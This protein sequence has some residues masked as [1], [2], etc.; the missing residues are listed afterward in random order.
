[1]TLKETL[2]KNSAWLL[3]GE[4]SDRIL[5]Y[6]LIII[7]ARMLGDVGLG[8]YSFIFA[9][10]QTTFLLAD[11]GVGDY[12]VREISQRPERTQELFSNAVFLKFALTFT[13]LLATIIFALS[14]NKPVY[15]FVAMIILSG[16]LILQNF[17]SLFEVVFQSRNEMHFISGGQIIERL[18]SLALGAFVL[19]KGKGLIIFFAVLFIAYTF[20][21]IYQAIS[22]MKKIGW[23]SIKSNLN[24]KTMKELLLGGI[25]LWLTGVFAFIYFR[26]D[27]IMLSLMVGDQ[28]VG[29]Y[30]AAYKLIDALN[31]IPYIIFGATFPSMS[32]LF[33]EDKEMLTNILNRVIRYLI[34]LAI[35]ITIGTIL[36]SERILQ[37]IYG[38]MFYNST[39]VLQILIVAEA[40]V[41]VTFIIA[42]TLN[43]MGKEKS[44]TYALASLSVFNIV[45]N[46]ILIPKYTYI[47]AAIATV[48]SEI[49]SLIILTYLIR[50]YLAKIKYQIIKPLIASLFMGATIYYLNFLAIW[51]L[52]IIGMASYLIIIY[53]LKL[54]EEDKTLM[55][56]MFEKI[57]SI[58]LI[59]KS[60]NVKI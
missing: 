56:E 9:A 49:L 5:S 38:K 43:S 22:F 17:G 13:G 11:M 60:N 57:K 54:P 7:L 55:K 31:F 18:I 41:F 8:E 19:L 40:L 30:S 36:L 42:K 39:L 59:F 45:L 52:L 46:Y 28:I 10:V 6:F 1:M 53:L 33:I 47:G 37:F 58:V 34:C 25:P 16:R 20:K 3:V 14:T 27:I 2:V 32:R 51:W 4:I 26:I 24:I 50:K 21:F 35:P 44:V 12:I 48:I 29:W 15:I 23:C